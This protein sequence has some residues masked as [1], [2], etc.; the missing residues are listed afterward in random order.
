MN[1]DQPSHVRLTILLFLRANRRHLAELF[2][3]GGVVNALMLTLP[4]FTM[5]VYDKAVGNQ[6]HDTLWALLVGMVLLLMLELVLRSARVTMIEHAGARWDAFLD[7]RLMRGVLAA[8]LSQRLHAGDLLGRLREVASTRDVLSAQAL[9]TVADLPFALMFLAVVTAIAGPLVWIP[10]GAALLLLAIGAG[11]QQLVS[12]R[13]QA[14]H[15]AGR[16]KL[17]VLMDVLSARESLA[18]QG[19]ATRALADWRQPSQVSSRQAARA[20]LWG[21]LNQ[22][23]VPVVM[24]ASTVTLLVCGVFRI[25]AQQLS[26]GG[27]I[28]ANML[29]GRLLATLC[30]V[31]PLVG[32][33]REFRGALAGLADSAQMASPSLTAEAQP[34]TSLALAQEGIRLQGLGF[35][36]P[37]LER[38]QL[39][40]LSLQLMPGQLVAVVGASGAGKSSL[41]KVLAGLQPHTE[42]RLTVGGCLIDGEPARRWLCTQAMHKAQDPCFYGGTLRE[43][44]SGCATDVPDDQVVSALRQ[45]GLGPILD[46]AELG[47]NSVI[48]T[49]GAGLSGGQKQMVAWATV[50]LSRHRLLL[51]DEPTL[52]LDRVT[53]EQLLRTL[54]GLR[55]GRCVLVATHATEVIQLADRV[56]VLDRGRVVA[57][58]T[59]SA[60]F[61]FAARPTAAAAAGHVT[62]VVSKN[63]DLVMEQ[64]EQM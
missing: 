33:W 47:L 61:G 45:A 48:G 43:V 39:S 2:L 7:E 62:K 1:A 31:M 32:R 15:Q 18:S 58:A 19:S 23:M 53:Q 16:R 25:E 11:V 6:V 64:Q 14:A 54:P 13:Q 24:S 27:L 4:L 60:L 36:Y 34:T 56:L 9:L 40:D 55:A 49:N 52:G 29:S 57:D 3:A 21:Q 44:V 63:T 37:N 41:L 35:R 50:L 10:V 28:S 17:A 59:P 22:Q 46:S 12:P 20:R 38:A 51:L 5:L 8:P 30:G 42:G 26:V